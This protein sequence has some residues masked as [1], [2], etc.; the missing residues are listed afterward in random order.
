M[1]VV[2]DSLPYKSDA[3]ATLAAL[4]AAQEASVGRV[5]LVGPRNAGGG[6]LGGL[7]G[8]GG[9]S[10]EKACLCVLLVMRAQCALLGGQS[11]PR[12]PTQR[13]RWLPWRPVWRWRRLS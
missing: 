7:F 10:P 8:G 13:W 9:G 1:V 3:K 2:G 11:A 6:F 5:L 4:A 12:G